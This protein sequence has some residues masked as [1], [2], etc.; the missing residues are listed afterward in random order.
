V[1]GTVDDVRV[2][3]EAR[4]IARHPRSWEREQYCFDPVHYLAL[5]ERKPGGFD[6]A[7]PLEHWELPEC[8]GALRR[9]LEADGWVTRGFIRVL[10]LL[11][12][13]SLR[14]LTD[15]VESELFIDVIDPDSIGVILDD[16]FSL[17][18]IDVFQRGLPISVCRC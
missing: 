16:G 5:L 15:A 11:E 10:P 4:L 3:F 14:Q 13:Y 17:V 18:L 6:F 8:L 9:R 1:I 12:I 2:V 7:K